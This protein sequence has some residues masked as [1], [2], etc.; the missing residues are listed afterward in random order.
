MSSDSDEDELLQMALNEQ[1]NRDVN[2]Q[3][4]SK[5]ASKPVRHYVQTPA[6]RVPPSVTG[7]S[8]NSGQRKG[9]NQQQRK[10]GGVEEDEDSEVE[11]LSISSG[12]EDDRGGGGARNRMASGR[13]DDKLYDGEE[14]NC[15]KRVNEA[16]VYPYHLVHTCA[17]ILHL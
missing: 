5:A 4:P 10:K 12:D 14:P 1:S 13:E 2:Y 11:M 15:W 8:A 3:K 7:R 6:N 17:C 16:E 9:I